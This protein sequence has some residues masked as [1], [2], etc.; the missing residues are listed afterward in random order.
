MTNQLQAPRPRLESERVILSAPFSYTG[1]TL[2]LWR[3][4]VEDRGLEASEAR[5]RLLWQL[6]GATLVVGAWV[7][8]T[9]WYFTFGLL[10]V[11]FRLLRRHERRHQ[12]AE[13]RHRET[14]E[15][16]QNGGP[17]HNRRTDA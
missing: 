11:P 3:W 5:T 15:A 4:A 2:R 9:M 12:A 10:V 14:L 7:G 16:I 13:L 1:A 8:V 6:A 17:N